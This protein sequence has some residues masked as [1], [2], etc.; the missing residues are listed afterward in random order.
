MPTA[1]PVPGDPI[2]LTD[3]GLETDLVFN[4]GVELPE[5]ASFPL[6]REAEGR[7]LLEAYYRAHAAVAVEHGTGFVFETPTWRSS[8]EWGERLGFGQADLD[9]VDR[10]A[11]ALVREVRDST[12]GLTG[13][14]TISGMIGPRGDGYV[15]G[16]AMTPQ[17]SRAYHGH[18]VQVLADAGCDMVSTLTMTYAGEAAGIALAARDAGIPVA[19]SFTVETD[20][21]LPDGS[22]LED[23]V[24]AV[25]AATDR[26]IRYVGINCAHPDHLR[27]AVVGGGDWVGRIGWLRANAS[28]QS[29][30]ELDAAE[31][32][33]DGDAAELAADY[34]ALTSLLPALTVVGGC[35][36][37]DVRHVRAI[38][39]ALVP[40]R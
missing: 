20:G 35:C 19:V 29:H 30:A 18:Q 28:R 4:Q 10:A 40:A 6:V 13:P 8:A 36:G 2:V 26:Y 33:D 34:A 16:T 1:P 32:L 5:F 11:V 37:T 23:A 22:T 12:S 27:P 7:A 25:D 3:S 31:V 15:V 17:E 21:L 39:G 14:T 24:A 9:E 38:A